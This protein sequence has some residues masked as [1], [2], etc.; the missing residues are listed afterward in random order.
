MPQ[1]AVK[2]SEP[3]FAKLKLLAHQERTTYAVIIER[4]LL[5]YEPGA[6]EASES[7]E[8][9]K[10][11]INS[12]LQPVLERLEMLES[13]GLV[14][15]PHPT[16]ITVEIAQDAPEP[17]LDA[18]PIAEHGFDQESPQITS[19][20]SEAETESDTSP[21]PVPAFPAP[22]RLTVKEFIAHL[23]ELGE[24]SPTK[25]AKALNQAGYRTK[26]GTPFERSSPQIAAA[27]KA[28][29]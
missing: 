14:K 8:E 11:L 29:D 2:I 28:K 4:A 5:A 20:S 27:L 22:A 16:S 26:T 6:S 7:S 1:I 23:V 9:I 19:Q 3:I 13:L 21:H 24:R 15:H 12:A 10:T 25:I 17:A 18:Q